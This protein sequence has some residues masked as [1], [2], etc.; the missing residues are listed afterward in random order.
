MLQDITAAM[1]LHSA[2]AIARGI[3]IPDLLMIQET[4]V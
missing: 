2:I 1:V 4:K 3:T